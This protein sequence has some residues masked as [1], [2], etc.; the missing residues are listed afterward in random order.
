DNE[1]LA[2]R[3]PL[4]PPCLELPRGACTQLVRYYG[5]AFPKSHQGS[6]FLDNWGAHGFNAGNRTIHRYV[7]DERNNIVKKEDWLTCADPHFRC[8]HIVVAPD[9]NMLIADWYGRDDESDLTGRIWKVKYVGDEPTPKVEHALDSADWK[10]R[11]YAAS[12]L[13]SPDHLIRAK[14]VEELAAQGD[15]AVDAVAEQAASA[16]HSLGAASALW[17]L[18]RINT[19]RSKQAIAKGALH[20]DWRVRRLAIN[21]LR[22]HD[23][24]D[25]DKVAAQLA[26]DPDPAVRVEAAFARKDAGS[27]RSAILDALR[28]GA[29]EDPHLRYEAAWRLAKHAGADDFSDLLADPD[30]SMR[31]AGLIAMDAALYERFP[32]REFALNALSSA[33]VSAK[34]GELK[35]LLKL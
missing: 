21:L 3:H 16:K 33:L 19:A 18:L 25:A 12:A 13:G 10:N 7:P 8:S 26:K 11:D 35:T 27:I 1:G 15:A 31:L 20:S 5:A 24:P 30:E 17:T 29:A 4:A 22:R 34:E 23:L 6:L 2:G 32:S 14:A 9:G 28:N